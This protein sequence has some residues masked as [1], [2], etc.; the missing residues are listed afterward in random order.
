VLF[1]TERKQINVRNNR[2]VSLPRRNS[3]NGCASSTAAPALDLGQ[4]LEP[5]FSPESELFE[6]NELRLLRQTVL[7]ISHE[8]LDPHLQLFFD[9]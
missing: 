6:G 1:G 3:R 8:F 5:N 2:K 4:S 9:A 7:A